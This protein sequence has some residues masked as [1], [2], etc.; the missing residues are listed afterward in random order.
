MCTLCTV[1]RDLDSAVK[2]PGVSCGDSRGCEPVCGMVLY[3][4][5]CGMMLC[6]PVCGMVLCNPVCGW[7]RDLSLQSSS[8]TQSCLSCLGLGTLPT[9]TVKVLRASKDQR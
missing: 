7:C 5:V 8:W 6:E 1:H 9:R 2:I 4:S 3:D